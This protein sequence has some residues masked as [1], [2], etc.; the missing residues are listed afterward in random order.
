MPG[1]ILMKNIIVVTGGAGFVGSNLIG[2]FLEKTN[3]KIISVDNYST[4]SKKTT[5]KIKIKYLISETS[6]I[7]LKLSKFKK[8][9]HTVF[10][11]GEFA[12]IYQSF[13]HFDECYDLKHY[14]YKSSF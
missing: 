11:F 7:N 6:K 9:I 14:W 1:Y 5:S 8:N 3:K 13:N 2:Y 10:H 12:R 4:G